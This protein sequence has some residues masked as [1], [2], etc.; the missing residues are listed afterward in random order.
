MNASLCPVGS[1]VLP[2]TPQPGISVASQS[3]RGTLW[4][5]P[6]PEAMLELRQAAEWTVRGAVEGQSAAEAASATVLPAIGAETATGHDDTRVQF[7]KHLAICSSENG[8][9]GIIN[10]IVRCLI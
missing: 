4:T 5:Q 8:G 7:S 6:L 3:T 1:R 2:G 9:R 10:I